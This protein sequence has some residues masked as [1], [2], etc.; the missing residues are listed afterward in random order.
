MRH[1]WKK[2]LLVMTVVALA[3]TSVS[4]ATEPSNPGLKDAVVMIIRHAEKP[5][6]GF[7]LS[8]PGEKRALAYADYFKH[9]APASDGQT[10]EPDCLIATADSSA[11]HRPRLTLEPLSRALG[12]KID[13]QFKNKN[14]DQ[15]AQELKSHEHGRRIL[16]CWHHGE[17]PELARALGA[18]PAR[19]LPDAKW[20][21]SEFGWVLM[22]RYDSEGRLEQSRC[23]SEHLMP[24]DK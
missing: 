1:A 6:S 2:H 9:F 19:L 5:E 18:D 8:D 4:F 24:G 23:I 22:M 14:F 10:L 7:A 20:P 21:A 13:A 17:I 3:V 12:L 11:S 16:I 15:L